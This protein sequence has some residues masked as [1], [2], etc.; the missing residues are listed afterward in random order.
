MARKS[1]KK[2]VAEKPVAT[3]NNHRPPERFV[4]RIKYWREGEKNSELDSTMSTN[5]LRAARNEFRRRLTDALGI[6]L[7]RDDMK[8]IVE[9][10][11]VVVAGAER[12]Y[13][14]TRLAMCLSD[15][16]NFV[17]DPPMFAF[18]FAGDCWRMRRFDP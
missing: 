10:G 5:S 2:S 18:S 15:L 11:Y 7:D 16:E 13:G 8:Q 4:L 14:Y 6:T 12:K 1:T 3:D 17:K 9:A